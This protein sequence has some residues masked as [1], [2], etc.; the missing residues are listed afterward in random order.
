M[1]LENIA[2]D[3]A[4]VTRREAR[5]QIAVLERRLARLRRLGAEMVTRFR[6]HFPKPPAYPSRYTDR[7]LTGYRWRMANRRAVSFE[8]LSD[9]GQMILD[10]L[11]PSARKIWLDFERQRIELNLAGAIADYELRRL[12]D[13]VDRLDRLRMAELRENP[14]NQ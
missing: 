12:R 14:G 6:W 1:K 5:T 8:L 7:T 3:F 4:P 2:E 11:P 9:T 13:Y 10:Q